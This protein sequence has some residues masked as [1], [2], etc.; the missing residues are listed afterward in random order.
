MG[1]P[2]F[3]MVKVVAVV[4]PAAHTGN[5]DI[6]IRD[7]ILFENLDSRFKASARGH[8]EADVVPV[9]LQ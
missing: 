9:F 7:V 3:V 4:D 5:D 1:L 6:R 2:P 8:T